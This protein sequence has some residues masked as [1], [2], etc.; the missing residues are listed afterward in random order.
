MLAE[1]KSGIAELDRAAEARDGD[2]AGMVARVNR[3]FG[4]LCL[5][6]EEDRPGTVARLLAAFQDAVDEPVEGT[7]S[8]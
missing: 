5:I 6:L 7:A 8:G 4:A 3:A 2:L 1:L